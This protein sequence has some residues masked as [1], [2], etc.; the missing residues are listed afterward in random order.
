MSK[1][2]FAAGLIIGVVGTAFAVGY[3]V[4]RKTEETKYHK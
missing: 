1:L 4:G 2:H 3:R